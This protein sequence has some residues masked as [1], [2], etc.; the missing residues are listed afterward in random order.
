MDSAEGHTL[1]QIR[2]A[3]Q[4]VE[5]E[6]QIAVVR[7]T[8]G[9]QDAALKHRRAG[10]TSEGERRLD[11]HARLLG[12]AMYASEDE[13]QRRVNGCYDVVLAELR[14]L[15]DYIDT[16]ETIRRTLHLRTA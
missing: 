16:M 9:T 12:E 4:R 3:S 11:L 7:A 5:R 6:V 1:S 2:A 8:T 15:S 10:R 14:E 13:W